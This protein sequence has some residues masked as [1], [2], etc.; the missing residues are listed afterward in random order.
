MS[1]TNIAVIWLECAV[2][3]WELHALS[4]AAITGSSRLSRTTNGRRSEVHVVGTT[5][6]LW[7]EASTLKT[8]AALAFSM[9]A[10][11]GAISKKP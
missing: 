11:S 1:R 8:R 9:R 5:V 7:R 4:N 6:L 2:D 3:H 10:F